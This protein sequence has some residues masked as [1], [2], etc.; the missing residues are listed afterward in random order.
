MKNE[1]L[2]VAI[3]G[4]AGAFIA[5]PHMRAIHGNST[6]QI[7]CGVLS[8]DP[9]KGIAAAENWPYPITPYASIAD[10]IKAR[11]RCGCDA[12]D[13]AVIVTPNNVHASQ[14]EQFIKAGIP[15]FLEKPVTFN[16]AEAQMLAK[17]AQE[18]NV[19][20]GVAHTYVGHWTTQLARHIVTSG[21]IG[22][23]RRVD[24]TYYQGWLAD[25]LERMPGAPGHQQ[26]YWR[27]RKETA[28]AS[29]CG[30]DIGTHALMQ[31]RY[32]T[33]LEVDKVLFARLTTMVDGR[34]LDDN[35]TTICLLDN[36]AEANISATQVAVGHK[37]GLRIEINGT[38]GTVIW[39]Q[40]KPEELHV[41]TKSGQHLVYYRGAVAAKGDA[42]L[43]DLPDSLAFGAFLPGGH[44]EGFHDAFSRLYQAFERHVR[45]WKDDPTGNPVSFDVNACGYPTLRDGV[46]GM[47]FIEVALRASRD[48]QEA[49]F[50]EL[51]W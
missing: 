12:V 9:A 24:A 21:K 19:P 3:V 28:G 37:N 18:M 47:R 1:K 13:F 50:G 39:E 20:V 45:A 8:R 48:K 27:T 6:A 25:P 11:Q 41:L 40:E 22:A 5:G 26:A 30:G 46:A 38:E 49:Y 31:L 17:L 42:F 34:E 14:A 33:G 51:L 29:C 10:L 15:V 16:L 43:G 7:S 4:G 2:N 36:G 23:V 44:P 32:V 35:F